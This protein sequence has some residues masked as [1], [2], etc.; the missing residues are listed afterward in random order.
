MCAAKRDVWSLPRREVHTV[1]QAL[2]GYFICCK[3][4]TRARQ[5]LFCVMITLVITSIV[6]IVPMPTAT[7]AASLATLAALAAFSAG[8]IGKCVVTGTVS[9]LTCNTSSPML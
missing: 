7:S 6:D 4:A 2:T 9:N 5:V 8:E 3:F 1:K